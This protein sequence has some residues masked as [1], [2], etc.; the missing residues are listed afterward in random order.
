[1]DH[2]HSVENSMT[3]GTFPLLLREEIDLRSSI[4]KQCRDLL[5]QIFNVIKLITETILTA[6]LLSCTAHL[7]VQDLSN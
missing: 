3:H 6:Y 2:V 7:R 4:G 1:M 5:I